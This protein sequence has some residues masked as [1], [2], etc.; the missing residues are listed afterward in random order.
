MPSL[1]FTLEEAPGLLRALASHDARL[2]DRARA[3]C[4][5]GGNVTSSEQAYRD[6][7]RALGLK[8]DGSPLAAPADLVHISRAER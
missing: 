4:L 2:F 8:P 5:T 6:G 1:D 7:C 3:A